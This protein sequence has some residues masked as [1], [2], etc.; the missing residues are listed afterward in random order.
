MAAN[1]KIS[2]SSANPVMAHTL[3]YLAIGYGAM[4]FLFWFFKDLLGLTQVYNE[5]KMKYEFAWLPKK[6]TID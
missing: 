4:I 6:V 1:A 3:A 2:T 5:D